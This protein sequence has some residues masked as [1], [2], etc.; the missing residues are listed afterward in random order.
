VRGGVLLVCDSVVVAGGVG[1]RD[2]AIHKRI[3]G[4][5]EIANRARGER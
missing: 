1:R 2:Q 5:E 3:S 4:A